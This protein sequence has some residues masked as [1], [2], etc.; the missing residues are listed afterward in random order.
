[1]EWLVEPL[2]YRFFL[3]GLVV[4]LLVGCLCGLLGVFI[5]LR[6]MSYIGHGLSHAIFGGA[7]ASYLLNVNFYLGAGLWGLI[8]VILIDKLSTRRELNPDAAIGIITTASFAVGVALMI[9][10]R[11]FIQDFEAALF[12][13]VLGVARQD[14]VII[15]V[16]AGLAGLAVLILYKPLL[17]STFDEEVA[18]VY[19]VPT[20]KIRLLFSCILAI[21]ILA[22]VQVLGVT[23]IAAAIV[24]P[25]TTSRL[26]TH[27]FGTMLGLS[28]VLGG[29]TASIGMYLSYYLD[30]AS[31]PSI[32]LFATLLFMVVLGFQ[33][34]LAASAVRQVVRKGD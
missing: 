31:G 3:H 11:R 10:T 1:M 16:V 15:S 5:V 17:F 23:L 33:H 22:S 28:T 8:S 21:S 9:R 13:N 14:L 7:V 20:R 12:G 29:L 34:L 4:A 27:N 26:L 25:A 18:Q 32:V 2:Q 6:K 24:I 19:G 30:I